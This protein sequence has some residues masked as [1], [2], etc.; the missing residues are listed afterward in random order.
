MGEN[1]YSLKN[2]V[3]RVQT[4]ILAK[5]E[6]GKGRVRPFAGAGVSLLYSRDRVVGGIIGGQSIVGPP[7][8]SHVQPN[9]FPVESS[10]VTGPMLTAGLVRSVRRLRLSAEIRYTRFFGDTVTLGLPVSS[11]VLQ[12]HENQVNLLIGVLF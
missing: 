3:N 6:F 1:Y 7:M 11:P 8:F 9:N 5:Y 2:S 12:S 4:T 10:V